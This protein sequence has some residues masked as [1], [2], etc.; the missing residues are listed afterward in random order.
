[1]GWKDAREW[2]VGFGGGVLGLRVTYSPTNSQQ[3][4]LLELDGFEVMDDDAGWE[5]L[6][7]GVHGGF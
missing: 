6:L 5:L 2:R 4:F 7:E 3:L 1:M